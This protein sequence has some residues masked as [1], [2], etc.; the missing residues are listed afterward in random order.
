[1][2]RWNLRMSTG[3]RNA[4]LTV[5]I[6]TFFAL[7][8]ISIIFLPG[9]VMSD[10][11]SAAQAPSRSGKITPELQALYDEY[12]TYIAANKS[13][14]FRSHDDSIRLVGD[15]VLIDAV[16]SGDVS[17]LKSDLI[18]LGVKDPVVFGRM[19]SCQLPISAIPDLTKLASLQFARTVGGVTRE[20]P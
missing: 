15:R 9:C 16:A 8:V 4:A 11:S 19:I 6:K 3:T 14:V 7:F 12:S 20:R 17:L 2:Q 5:P 10:A 1:M 13:G 18:A